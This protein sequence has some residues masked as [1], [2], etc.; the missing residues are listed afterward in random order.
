MD[1]DHRKEDKQIRKEKEER[2]QQS[3]E[4]E[5]EFQKRGSGNLKGKMRTWKERERT[6]SPPTS[7]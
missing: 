6:F 2:E 3:L 4:G 1:I 7:E 5:A